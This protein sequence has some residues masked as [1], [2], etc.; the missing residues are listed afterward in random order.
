MTPRPLRLHPAAA[1]HARELA[2][3]QLTR[4]EFLTRV[5]ALG[6][7][8]PAA[9]ALG[10][11]A[12]PAR[13]DEATESEGRALRIQMEVRPLKDPRTADWSEIAN[14]YRGWLEYLV[15]YDRDG[16]VRGMLLDAWQVSDDATVYTLHV[17]PGVTWNNGDAFTAD[18]V[19]RMFAYWCD[20]RVE[21]NSMAGRLASLVD[22]DTDRLRDGAVTVQDDLTVTLTLQSPDVALMVG[23]SDYPA[24][25]VHA[26]HDPLSMLDSP[27]GT[28]PY[29]PALL[30]P[31]SRALLRRNRNHDWWGT[32]AV[33]YGGATLDAIEF[34][35]YG[36]DPAS[37]LAAA[38]AGEIDMLY[39]NIGDFIALADDMGWQ[40]S[41]VVTGSTVVLRGNQT[42]R[43]DGRAL[44]GDLRARKALQLAVDNAIALELGYDGH[45]VLAENHHVAPVHPDY[46]PIGTTEYAP[47]AALPLMRE[48][49]MADVEHDLVT[50]D[51]GLTMRTGDACAAMLRDAGLKVKRTVLPGSRFWS[52]WKSYPLSITE[53]NHRPL[54]IQ[55]LA[56]A[57]RSGEAWNESGYANPAFD[58]LVSEALGIAEAGARRVVM[59]KLERML[60]DDAVIVQP[61][62]RSL[63]RHLRPGVTGGDMHP[64]FEIHLYKLGLADG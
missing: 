62:W 61:Y 43:I 58:A 57:Y 48:A 15:E 19:A 17:R 2:A 59:A 53:W 24:A 1:L 63:Y 6:V 33:G 12:G 22:H 18:D 30:E 31:G 26:D 14:F 47:A 46:A 20:R 10:G 35:D 13:A 50:L 60:Q 34:I 21:G 23:L 44:Y 37:W 55:M 51:D 42:A 56:L 38:K 32:H 25:V 29:L 8:A 49:G 45:G 52:E 64:A 39:E 28:G 41:E 7:A 5:T 40:R 11:L 54:G 4:R 36:T 9:Y 27:L 3:G 16:T